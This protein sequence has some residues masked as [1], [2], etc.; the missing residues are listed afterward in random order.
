MTLG[1]GSRILPRGRAMDEDTMDQPAW[2]EPFLAGLR[3]NKGV[4]A[5]ARAAKIND[6]TARR[7]KAA[8]PKFAAAWEAIGPVDGRRKAASGTRRA[9]GAAKLDAFLEH[10][11]E[12][13]NVA[14]AAAEA[15]VS[16]S[17]IYKLRRSD[18]AFAQRW[19]AALA[20]GY[21]NLEM[22]VL[23]RLRAGEAGAAA[24]GSFDTAAALR[25]LA[26]HRESV[27]REKGRR[28]LEREVTT[29]ASINAKIDRLRLATE[30]GEAAMATARKEKAARGKTGKPGKA[31][32]GAD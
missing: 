24:K 4:A 20:E 13:S 14:G 11:A 19:F 17:V 23:G 2:M 31:R 7:R 25:C 21:D 6:S 29:I 30:A 22:E 5:A 3:E 9:H 28:T 8:D 27:A 10:L 18:P 16:L 15:G 26:A 1:S 32:S 12:T